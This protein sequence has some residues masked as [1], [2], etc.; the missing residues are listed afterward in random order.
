[1]TGSSGKRRT[2]PGEIDIDCISLLALRKTGPT[3]SPFVPEK[4][5]SS[6]KTGRP[7]FRRVFVVLLRLAESAARRHRVGAM[8]VDLGP[9]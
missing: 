9:R 4:D 3:K 8:R 1:M 6:A 5:L 7:A 2:T